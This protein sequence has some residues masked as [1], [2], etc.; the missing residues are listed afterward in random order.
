MSY[1][2]R[3]T[4][5]I[6]RLM[7]EA[8]ERDDIKPWCGP[9]QIIVRGNGNV[10]GDVITINSTP[11]RRISSRGSRK[12]LRASTMSFIRSTCRSLADPQQVYA[13]IR[14][15][16]G[17]CDLEDLTDMQLER[18]RGWCAAQVRG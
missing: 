18:V 15:E 3:S 13:F 17:V 5:R 8:A 11:S 16:F 2:E 6:V 7:R 9:G 10:L 4:E 1:S 14:D 12:V